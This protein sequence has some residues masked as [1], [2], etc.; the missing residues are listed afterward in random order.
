MQFG[1]VLCC[2]VGRIG[3]DD[4][5]LHDVLT[6]IRHLTTLDESELLCLPNAEFYL[7]SAAQMGQLFHHFPQAIRNTSRIADRCQFNLL[8]GLQT[9]PPYPIPD[10][11]SG[12][13]FLK[14]RCESSDRV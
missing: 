14:Q 4:A 6:C 3:G 5:K 9:L 8:S 7:K 11:T 2:I 10:G 1:I 12:I 13:V